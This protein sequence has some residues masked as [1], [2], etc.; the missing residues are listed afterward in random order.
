MQRNLAVPLSALLGLGIFLSI[1]GSTLAA[2][3][4]S[5]TEIR[6]SATTVSGYCAS[7]KELAFLSLINDYRRSHGLGTLKLTQTLGAASEHHSMSMATHNYFSHDLLYEGIT[8][9]QNIRNHGYTYNTALGENIAAGRSSAQ[10]TFDQWRSS[11]GHNAN[12]LSSNYKAIGIGLVYSSSSTYGYY[13]TTD[14]GG[15]ADGGAKTCGGSEGGGGVAGSDGSY[16]VYASGRTSNSRSSAYCYDGRQ[17]T[18][19][20]TI[21]SSIPRYAYMWYD[22]GAVRSIG[23]IKWKFN[24][25]GYSDHLEI[26]ISNDRQTW[27]T[28]ATRGNAPSNTWQTLTKN[29]SARYVRWLFR[30]PNNDSRLGYLSE[31]RAFR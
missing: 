1:A 15:Y 25:T 31:A 2:P 6:S 17:D 29:V 14:F 5:A 12:M 21:T 23:S 9:V 7:T 16:R 28:I 3:G 24:R 30:N 20:Y 4:P 22:L 19:W 10:G 11:S 18:S 26:Q 27:T 8:W 13:W